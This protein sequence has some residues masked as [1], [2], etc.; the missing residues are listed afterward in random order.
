MLRGVVA[1]AEF[2][3][4]NPGYPQSFLRES[5]EKTCVSPFL[6][7][8]PWSPQGPSTCTGL[9]RPGFKSWLG[10]CWLVVIVR[11]NQFSLGTLFSHPYPR[12][13]EH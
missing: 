2:K 5:P 9:K 8:P 6:P 13:A 1:R 12:C 11:A 4:P 7:P 3:T 10:A